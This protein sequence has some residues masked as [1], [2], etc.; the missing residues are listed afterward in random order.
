MTK[1]PIGLKSTHMIELFWEK[2]RN[3]PHVKFVSR[4]FARKIIRINYPTQ[5]E[6]L[7]RIAT[8]AAKQTS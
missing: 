7:I 1:S 4:Y 3:S 2:E 5:Q 8:D 6:S